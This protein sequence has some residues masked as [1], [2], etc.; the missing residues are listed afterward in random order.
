[1]KALSWLEAQWTGLGGPG[2]IPSSLAKA[3]ADCRAGDALAV[4]YGNSR[5][6]GTRTDSHCS[7]SN[8]SSQQCLLRNGTKART[9]DVANMC[10]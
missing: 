1:M 4:L 6:Q 7:L 2:M 10:R 3:L 5:G 9:D 8:P